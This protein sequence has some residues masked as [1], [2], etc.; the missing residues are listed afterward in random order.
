VDVCDTLNLL[1]YIFMLFPWRRYSH[2][3][4]GAMSN[5]HMIIKRIVNTTTGE[6]W[7]DE[8]VSDVKFGGD[9]RARTPIRTGCADQFKDQNRIMRWKGQG[10]EQLSL[11]IGEER[12]APEA[13]FICKT[14]KASLAISGTMLE[15][16]LSRWQNGIV[17]E[18]YKFMRDEPSLSSTLGL[19]F[20][21][22]LSSKHASSVSL[23]QERNGACNESSSS[24]HRRNAGESKISRDVHFAVRVSHEPNVSFSCGDSQVTIG[25]FRVYF[26]SNKFRDEDRGK[27]GSV[28]N[29]RRRS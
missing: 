28:V 18:T 17:L 4:G 1:K 25:I 6:D 3:S 15:F 13:S 26:S 22:Q 16:R 14:K 10:D 8:A 7:R 12:T 2:M 9:K 20:D 21:P 23:W 24:V 5:M 27:I 11:N 19:I 29:I